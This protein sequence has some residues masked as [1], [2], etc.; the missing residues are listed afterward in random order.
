MFQLIF[1]CLGFV[2]YTASSYP[3]SILV[4][5]L[6]DYLPYEFRLINDVFD[7]SKNYFPKQC[8]QPHEGFNCLEIDYLE[9]LD[10]SI[11]LY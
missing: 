7:A 1:L 10:N 5:C 11:L 2:K 3:N 9:L 8:S 4:V 6:R